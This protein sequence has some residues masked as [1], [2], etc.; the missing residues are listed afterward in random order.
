MKLAQMEKIVATI[1]REVD[2]NPEQSGK[3]GMFLNYYL[4]TTEKLLNAY[5]D[6]NE[7]EIEGTSIK[8]AKRDIEH[9][10]D[11][12]I[13]S[14]EGILNQFYEEQELDIASDIATME[15]LIKQEQM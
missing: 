12:L 5:I 6:I 15:L 13:V 9:A 7:K 1:L 3:L 14:F 10:I 2:L 4:P 11:M 8:N